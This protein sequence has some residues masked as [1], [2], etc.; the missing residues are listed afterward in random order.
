[1]LIGFKQ[2]LGK[3]LRYLPNPLI[4]DV[5]NAPRF[6]FFDWEGVALSSESLIEPANS[7]SPS[8]PVVCHRGVLV[9]FVIVRRWQS[10]RY[11]PATLGGR[12]CRARYQCR[13]QG[14][15]RE[16]MRGLRETWIHLCEVHEPHGENQ[17]IPRVSV[18]RLG[19]IRIE[20]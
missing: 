1:M 15:L 18:R 6:S 3:F 11:G 17:P 14:D 20:E 10:V 9:R 13:G 8:I 7:D 4:V 19:I 5:P 12:L 2:S 16:S